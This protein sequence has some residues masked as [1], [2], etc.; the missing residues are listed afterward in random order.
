M[1]VLSLSFS[2]FTGCGDS[3]KNDDEFVGHVHNF[4]KK[5]VEDK[6]LASTATCTER[7][8][9][10]YSCD[11]GE[12][13]WEWFEYGDYA[14]RYKDNKC[15]FCGDKKVEYVY[16]GSYPQSR[17]LNETI[18]TALLNIAGNPMNDLTNWIS[19]GYFINGIKSDAC[20]FYV[21][22]DF[23]G[24][25]YRGVYIN[26]YRPYLS[27]YASVDWSTYQAAQ[28][29]LNKTVY[30]F[31]YDPIEWIIIDQNEEEATLLCNAIIDSQEFDFKESDNFS[32]DYSESLIR[33]WLN[34]SFYNTA[35]NENQKEKIKTTEVDN[36]P[37]S[38]GFTSNIY[39]CQNTFDKVFLLSCSE[40]NLLLTDKLAQKN[41]TDYAQ[42][43]GSYL[44]ESGRGFWWLRSPANNKNDL[45]GTIYP[46]GKIYFD[47]YEDF[48]VRNYISVVPAIKIKIV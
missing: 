27:N 22:I 20:M 8:T 3:T 6:F 25:K 39:A 38:T 7:A 42:S 37:Q 2:F 46:D 28:G 1:L 4:V 43:Q 34:E 40:I 18:T 48:V 23:N 31:E 29:Y 47:Y 14:H 5:V 24:D 33:T 19:Y 17:V 15:K 16:F 9:Y 44:D 11:C 12:Y 35:F 30:W 13:G 26:K 45:V 41:V 21:D 36:S 10:F 32:N